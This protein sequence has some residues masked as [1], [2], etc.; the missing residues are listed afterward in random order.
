MTGASTSTRAIGTTAVAAVLALAFVFVYNATAAPSGPEPAGAQN[1]QPRAGRLVGTVVDAETGKPVEFATVQ[2]PELRR[3]GITAEDGGF[4]IVD[5]PSGHY[6]LRVS[7]VGYEPQVVDFDVRQGATAHLT[8]ELTAAV[9]SGRTVVVSAQKDRTDV[10]FDADHQISGQNLQEKMGQTLAVTLR[11]VPGI[12]V[13]SMGPAAS[14]PVVRG[15]GGDRLKLLEDGFSSGDLSATSSDHAVAFD[16]LNAEQIDV[17]RGP[18]ALIYSSNALGGVIDMV[19]ERIPGTMPDATH[20]TMSLQ[21]E[22]VNSGGAVGVSLGAPVGPLALRLDGVGRATGDES[23]PEGTLE[24]SSLGSYDVS[25]GA[26]RVDT[27]GYAGLDAGAYHSDYGVP[28]GFIG[29]HAAGVRVV[30]DKYSANARA[31]IAPRAALLDA[32]DVRANFVRYGHQEI[33]SSGAVGTEFGQ[34]TRDLSVR[35]DHGA[36]GPLVR[37]TVGFD[38]SLVDLAANGVALEHTWST[39][40]AAYVYEELALDRLTVRGS[41]RFDF[42]DIAPT[43]DRQARI[44]HIRDR[45][46]SGASAS[47][48]LSWNVLDGLTVGGTVIHTY[49][50]PSVEELFSEG[51]HLAAFSYEVGDPDLNEETGLGLEADVDLVTDRTQLHLAA[52]RN[53]ISDY[54]YLR[55]T[56][57][58]ALR[59]P[60]PLYQY[61]NASA[62]MVGG[63]ASGQLELLDGLV[64]GASLSY[65]QGTNQETGNP[66]PLI[67]PLQWQSNL[68]YG[69]HGWTFGL[70]LRGAAAQH[71]LGE[72]E[73]PTDGYAVVDADAGYQFVFGAFLHSI[74]LGV[75]NLFDTSYRNHLSR[76]K[77]IRPEPGINVRL[78]YKAQL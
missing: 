63:E 5:L 44:G 20:G 6:S 70:G 31:R 51:P 39:G 27:W 38:G 42:D 48:A 3:G 67:P 26:S 9:L 53:A 19:R 77:V 7:M 47:A 76:T 11:D 69:T 45:S 72:F 60:L 74:T 62:L 32:I 2:L 61:S 23:T 1:A 71:R 30:V 78:M 55:N 52:Y 65:V 16:A 34:V 43:S 13:R 46:F 54:I 17:V 36:L 68:R 75:D 58:T 22:S 35:L 10:T 56:G 40:A 64:L 73:T 41:A 15:L 24:N 28:G 12:A 14:R 37:G 49:R 66:L 50:V 33:E 8:V 57:D 18:A 29:A 59:V 21:G 25:L 4:S